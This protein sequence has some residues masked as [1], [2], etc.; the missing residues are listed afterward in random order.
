ML[1]GKIEKMNQIIL[2]KDEKIRLLE[3]KISELTTE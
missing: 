3:G 2:V 1:E